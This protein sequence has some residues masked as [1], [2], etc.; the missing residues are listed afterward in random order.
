ML[1]ALLLATSLQ[2]QE[3]SATVTPATRTAQPVAAPHTVRAVRR[4]TPI[5]LDGAL[6]DPA[7]AAAEPVTEFRQDEPDQGALPTERTEVRVVFDDEA[8]Y[9]GARLFD[10]APDSIVGRL[11]RRDNQVVS[12]RF[13]LYLDPYHDRRTGVFFGINAAGT[14]YDGTLYNDDWNDDTWDGIW[15]AKVAHDSLGWSVEMRIPYSQLRF[16]QSDRYLWGINF[17]RDLARRNEQAL[18]AYT[19]RSESGFVSR[20]FDLEGIEAV[21]PPRRLEFLPYV[22]SKAE[23]LDHAAGDPFNSGR[24]LK[25]TAGADFKLGIGSNLTLDATVNPDFGQVEVDPAVVNLTDVET[26]YPEKRPFF[27]EGANIFDFGFG[28]ANNFWGFNWPGPDLFYSRRIGRPPQGGL[29]DASYADVPDGTTIL[30]AAK[31]SGKIGRSLSVGTL[32]ALTSR[33]TARLQGPGGRFQAEVEPLTSYNV[34]RARREFAEGRQSLGLIGTGTF[35]DLGN[36]ALRDQLTRNALALGLDGW[37]FLDKGKMWVVTGWAAATRVE[38]STTRITNL[39]RNS[40]HYFQR[41]DARHV[42]VDSG[43][44]AL[45]G[46]AG[47]LWLHKQRGNWLV[48]AALGGLSPGFESNDL[49]FLS[50]TDVLNGHVVLSRRWPEPGRLFRSA[51]VNTAAYRVY[52][53]DGD[54]TGEGYMLNGGATFLNY[55]GLSGFLLYVPE[56]INPRAT[57]GG[58]LMLGPSGY[59]AD[60]SY[61]TDDRKSLIGQLSLSH[62]RFAQDDEDTWSTSVSLEWRPTA[63]VSFRLEPSVERTRMGAQY[64][65]TFS[66][67][68][69]TATYG[70]R[71]VFGHLDQTTVAASLRLN[72]TFS[73][74][75]SLEL[76]T[77]PLLSSG[78]YTAFKEL[79]R[80]RS[81]A[82]RRFG[83]EGSTITPVTN[84]DGE[85]TAYDVDPGTGTAAF[86]FG[87]P[88]FS[89]ASLR[90]NAVLRWEYLAGSTLFLVW[91]QDRSDNGPDGDFQ[92][93]RSL[94]R[95]ISARGNNVFAVKLSYWW[96]P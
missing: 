79:R 66:D 34:V 28:G 90:G 82:F 83:T 72:W 4:A 1:V 93:N 65:G 25:A 87:N 20:F 22:T 96:H 64:V 35:R 13:S 53:F 88:D 52:N 17:R 91:T 81:Y 19:P 62:S 45:N 85:V 32:S 38:G 10:S 60:A 23:F 30:G 36:P 54:R 6:T 8:I 55:H 3:A 29:P 42:S 89:F 92:F 27:I 46:W 39:Q 86:S 2:T 37:T 84:A 69:A 26:F 18:L 9:V 12:D 59:S 76:Y 16:Q 94:R 77:Q 40:T 48:N 75:L 5:T 31:L 49:G 95:L 51:R 58:P 44:T 15:E 14:M 67:P 70:E 50:R 24:R 33:E 11:A 47:R 57:R 7:W 78:N 73:P 74:R 41:P 61:N 71:Y 80:P 68:A 63:A 21:R 56:R 43:A